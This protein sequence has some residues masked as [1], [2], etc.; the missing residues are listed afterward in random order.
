MHIV[1]SVNVLIF[2]IFVVYFRTTVVVMMWSCL[3]G[4]RQQGFPSH[5]TRTSKLGTL[6]I[7]LVKL[8]SIAVVNLIHVV[9]VKLNM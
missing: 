9:T 3:H 4:H 1:F 5:M 7:T 6:Q 8:K 2:D